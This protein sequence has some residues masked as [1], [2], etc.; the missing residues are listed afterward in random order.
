[1]FPQCNYSLSGKLY[2]NSKASLPALL[3]W[4]TFHPRSHR[5]RSRKHPSCH[6]DMTYAFIIAVSPSLQP[7]LQHTHTAFI[8]SSFWCPA[9]VLL[10]VATIFVLVWFGNPFVC[11]MH[12]HV[13]FD[14]FK[15][16]IRKRKCFKVI[17]LQVPTLPNRRQNKKE[18]NSPLHHH[19]YF[20]IP[21]YLKT[22]PIV[23][24]CIL[25]PAD[26]WD[27]KIYCNVVF[28]HTQKCSKENMALGDFTIGLRW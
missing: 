24:I 13:L 16:K 1:M 3:A 9:S 15:H 21:M 10:C 20:V 4:Q 26:Q 7:F 27:G 2:A 8:Q 19:L 18:L 6:K 22:W 25:I 17:Y 28:H 11:P 5:A 12:F 23:N 14:F